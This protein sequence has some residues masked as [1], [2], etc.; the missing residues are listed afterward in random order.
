[1][2]D[3]DV[4]IIGGGIQ[5]VGVL[6]DLASRQISSAHL[7][8]ERTLAIG[9]SSRSTKLLHGG[10]RYLEQ[11]SQWGLV[12]EALKERGLL[13]RL[14]GDVVRPVPFV[15]PATSGGRPAWMLRL[16]LGLY[17]LLAGDSGLPKSRRLKQFEVTKLA[18]Y[19]HSPNGS[20]RY[21]GAFLYHDGQML[22]DV[23]VQIAARAAQMMGASWESGARV[24]SIERIL[25]T[26]GS[27]IGYRVSGTRENASG[28]QETFTYTARLI[29]VTTGAWNNANLLKWGLQP[30]VPCILN[31]GSHIV[32]NRSV[33]PGAPDPNE[34]AATL[35]QNNDKRVLFF[36]PWFGRW[37]YGTTESAFKSD[38]R[39][40][41]PPP[42]DRDYLMS[43]ARLHLNLKD[44]DHN[45]EE[46]FAGVRTMPV[47]SHR[48]TTALPRPSSEHAQDPFSSPWYLEATQDNLSRLSRESVL[49]EPAE[50]ILVV[51][52]GKYTTYRSQA[53]QIGREVKDRLRK[54]TPSQTATADAWFLDRIREEHPEIF[55]SSPK[56][57]SA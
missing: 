44:P 3:F 7:L 20:N 34:C 57:R 23:I 41:L 5:G 19:L 26:P 1:V 27:G 6:H 28:S 52:G 43:A 54:G 10:L 4:L 36:I 16:G 51:Y 21:G 37:L 11:F 25:P 29:I 53:E 24:E 39:K 46:F 38:P 50:N 22:D 32:F 49:S 48:V 17:D 40:L 30:T 8:E 45:I 42:G 2:T 55:E 18:P 13:L 15:L 12:R 47:A 14:L 56:L 35:L 31:V 9:S 33:V